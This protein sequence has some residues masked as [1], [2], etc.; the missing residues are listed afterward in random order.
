MVDV[1]VDHHL[2]THVSLL[3][4]DRFLVPFGHLDGFVLEERVALK[5]RWPHD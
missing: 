2:L 4:H 1:L 5:R 3:R